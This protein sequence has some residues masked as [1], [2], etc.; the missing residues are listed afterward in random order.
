LSNIVSFDLSAI[1][2]GF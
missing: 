2:S 1:L